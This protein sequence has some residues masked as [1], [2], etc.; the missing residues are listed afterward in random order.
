MVK[1]IRFLLLK[2]ML[3]TAFYRHHLLSMENP[4]HL[5][6]HFQANLLRRTLTNLAKIRKMNIR[7]PSLQ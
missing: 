2:M 5:K 6:E 4:K 7:A 3:I 1:T